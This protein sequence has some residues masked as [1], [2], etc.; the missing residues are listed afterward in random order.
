MKTR[1]IDRAV[2]TL[3]R[4]RREKPL[5]ISTLTEIV[6]NEMRA[7]L[8]F[9]KERSKGKRTDKNSLTHFIFYTLCREILGMS[10]EETGIHTYREPHIINEGI[11]TA[12]KRL[13]NTRQPIITEKNHTNTTKR[14]IQRLAPEM[15]KE[16]LITKNAIDSRAVDLTEIPLETMLDGKI[17][18]RTYV[19]NFIN[20]IVCSCCAKS[21]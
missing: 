19:K 14:Y 4:A 15:L 7:P 20:M 3:E 9:K 2:Q 6:R 18:R 8:G 12:R 10:N 17:R 16:K 1:Y 21:S 5:G 13:A 11:K